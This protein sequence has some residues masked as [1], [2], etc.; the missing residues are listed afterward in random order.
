[1]NIPYIQEMIRDMDLLNAMTS[2]ATYLFGPW[3]YLTTI[4][5]GFL[6][7]YC[8]ERYSEMRLWGPTIDLLVTLV[9]LS[10]TVFTLVWKMKISEQDFT[11]SLFGYELHVYLFVHKI[12][13]LLANCW[14]VF[15]CATKRLGQ[16]IIEAIDITR[17]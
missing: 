14:I 1:M 10:L 7:G 4:V 9:S 15:A 12:T 5:I 13:Y 6:L 17:D 3:N 8:L 11:D 16:Y 2:S